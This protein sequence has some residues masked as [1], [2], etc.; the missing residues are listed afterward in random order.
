MISGVP[1]VALVRSL[2]T[3]ISGAHWVQS[4]RNPEADLERIAS[5]L[6]VTWQKLEAVRTFVLTRLDFVLKG[7][8]V[9][10][11]PLS[12]FKY[13]K[14]LVTKWMYLPQQA[15]AEMANLGLSEEGAGIPLISDLVDIF[16][17]V[18]SFRLIT[19]HDPVVNDPGRAP[20]V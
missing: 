19:C 5:S 15:S 20:P 12:E 13:F 14:R 6:L 17:V 10:E 16:S 7:A 11:G 8:R 3:A 4:Q 1:I 2:S 18:H 9:A